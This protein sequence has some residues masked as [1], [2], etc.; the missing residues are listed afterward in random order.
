MSGENTRSRVWFYYASEVQVGPIGCES[1]RDAIECGAVGLEDYVFR[2]GFDDWRR[3]ADIEELSEIARASV[4][5]PESNSGDRTVRS[6]DR[7]IQPRAATSDLV[8]AH[9]DSNLT[10]GLV[11]EISA[12]GIFIET[13]DNCFR[14]ND[15]IK[16][17]IKQNSSLG[18]PTL[19]R[20][21][22]VRQTSIGGG[23]FGYGVE[24]M[25]L[26]ERTRSTIAAYVKRT[27]AS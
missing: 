23:R 9:N 10:S 17:T 1:L 20:G 12:S 25:N 11:T 24:L 14:L 3:L 27:Q 19:L 5:A 2:E 18:K 7:R 26:D 6:R 21:T 22:V 15:E 16:V 4:G 8:V 13:S